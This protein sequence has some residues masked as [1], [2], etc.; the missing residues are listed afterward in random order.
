MAF[1]LPV[2]IYIVCLMSL[3]GLLYTCSKIG[4]MPQRVLG[5]NRMSKKK[6]KHPERVL[7]RRESVF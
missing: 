1:A 5:A 3:E 7:L 2:C 4:D 6:E